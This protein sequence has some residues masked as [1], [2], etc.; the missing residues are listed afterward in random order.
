MAQ[1]SKTGNDA[2]QS[3]AGASGAKLL[4]EREVAERWGISEVTLQDWRCRQKGPPFIRLGGRMIRY[5]EL[6][7]E[8]WLIEQES[9]PAAMRG[10]H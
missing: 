4:S 9:H 2:V 1:Y 6:D 7:I 10:V 3:N 8:I 5:R